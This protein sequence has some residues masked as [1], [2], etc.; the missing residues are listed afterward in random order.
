MLLADSARRDN[1]SGLAL[2]DND[3][4]VALCTDEGASIVILEQV[5]EQTWRVV[6]TV[7]VLAE[8][9]EADLES[10]AVDDQWLYAVGSHSAR[11]K[12]AKPDKSRVKN[13]QRLK[14]FGAQ[15]SHGFVHRERLHVG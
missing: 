7:S 8:D 9:S 14:D 15:P 12:R 5:Q 6:N 10:V 3:R 4:R 1:I 2:F 11:R 13:R